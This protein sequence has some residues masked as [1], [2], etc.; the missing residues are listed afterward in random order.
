MSLD[1]TPPADP[2][3]V[4][5]VPAAAE[6]CELNERVD[7]LPPA[8][9]DAETARLL[10]QMLTLVPAV[11]LLPR[12]AAGVAAADAHGL[13]L[14]AFGLAAAAAYLA[15]VFGR[16]VRP[17]RI[18]LAGLVGLAAAWVL[19]TDVPGPVG[20]LVTLL[21]AV[22]AGTFAAFAVAKQYTHYAAADLRLDW[23]VSDLVRRE[24]RAFEDG[25]SG[26]VEFRSAR[27]AL[28]ALL[29]M[30]LAADLSAVLLPLPL[31]VL[32]GLLAV[33]AAV[34]PAGTSPAA[35]ARATWRAVRAFLTYGRTPSPAPG[36]FRLPT[37]WLRPHPA[38]YGVVFAALGLLALS[39]GTAVPDRVPAPPAYDLPGAPPPPPAP[40]P[41]PP[42]TRAE[43]ARLVRT[44]AGPA[45]DRYVRVLAARRAAERSAHDAAV[46]RYWARVAAAAAGGLLLAPALLFALI[47]VPFGPALSAYD[48]ALDRSDRP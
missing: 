19:Q 32:G 34:W 20:G 46:R 41:V 17:F 31:A 42:R 30:L 16:P 14:T 27:A 13:W 44:P 11:A 18:G 7:D 12:V 29:P 8:A 43:D 3:D 45:R 33:A 37:R 22:T 9:A 15:Y 47:A 4:K 23:E 39:V 1:W 6:A 35:V 2:L 48:H 38:R 26:A 28:A 40:D 25:T 24:W 10:L 21:P 5:A 36:V